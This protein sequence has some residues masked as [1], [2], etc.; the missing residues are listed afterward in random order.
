MV[1]ELRNS[2]PMELHFVETM[3]VDKITEEE[4][5]R[6]AVSSRY[7]TV[8]IRKEAEKKNLGSTLI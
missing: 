1:L 2:G 4:T 3:D 6:K 5:T 7:S 8:L